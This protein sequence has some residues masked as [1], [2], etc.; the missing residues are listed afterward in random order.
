MTHPAAPPGLPPGTV[1]DLPAG[2]F[3]VGEWAAAVWRAADLIPR[4]IRRGDRWLPNPACRDGRNAA[5]QAFLTTCTHL[6]LSPSQVGPC[7]ACGAFHHLYGPGGTPLCPRC[8]PRNP[9]RKPAGRPRLT[10]IRGGHAPAPRHRPADRRP[11][12]PGAACLPL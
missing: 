9:G 8:R 10:L 11:P 2:G 6:G 12:P 7:A 1:L 3:T 5:R 4:E